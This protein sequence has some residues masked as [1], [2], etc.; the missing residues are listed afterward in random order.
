MP[1]GVL[2]DAQRQRMAPLLPEKDGPGRTAKTIAA[3]WKPFCGQPVP[4]APWR[5]LP[6]EFGLRSPVFR[7]RA[8][9]GVFERVFQDLPADADFEYVLVDGTFVRRHQHGVAPKGH[10]AASLGDNWRV[11]F[12]FEDGA[13]ADVN[14]LDDHPFRL[15][16]GWEKHMAM[17][18]PTHPAWCSCSVWSL[19]ACPAGCRGIGCDSTGPLE[20]SERQD[21]NV[22]GDGGT[23]GK[24]IRI[25]RGNVAGYAAGL[26]VMED[27]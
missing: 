9:R 1:R 20:A 25:D 23:P 27:T 6:P 11:T 5:E 12:R 17:R 21:R 2:N 24:G 3:F 8:L 13:A 10:W 14:Y 7:S 15:L 22:N 19:W 18:N 4:A 26:R 16:N